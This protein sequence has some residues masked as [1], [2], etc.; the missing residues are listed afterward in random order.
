MIVGPA[1]KTCGV[2]SNRA[3][4]SDD[5]ARPPKQR[6]RYRH[7]SRFHGIFVLDF[8]M[9]ISL[10]NAA[11]SSSQFPGLLFYCDGMHSRHEHAFARRLDPGSITRFAQKKV[12]RNKLRILMT[13]SVSKILIEIARIRLCWSRLTCIHLNRFYVSVLW[14][15]ILRRMHISCMVIF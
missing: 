3:V 13:R 5:L 6:K 9:H 11:T 8:C 10:S 4:V 2:T 7:R 1:G 15:D 12:W 14:G